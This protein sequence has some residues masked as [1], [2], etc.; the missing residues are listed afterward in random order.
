MKRVCKI[1]PAN[2][3]SCFKF[4]TLVC[5]HWV[6]KQATQTSSGKFY[7]PLMK[8]DVVKQVDSPSAEAFE[9]R[10]VYGRFYR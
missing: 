4:H 9:M 7:T 2:M 6:T 10:G 8:R 1:F 3:P 5:Y